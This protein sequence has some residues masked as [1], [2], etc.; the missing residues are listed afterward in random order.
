MTPANPACVK[1]EN[2]AFHAGSMACAAIRCKTV[3]SVSR[4]AELVRRWIEMFNR[5]GNPVEKLPVWGGVW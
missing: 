5:G 2:R 1:S 4:L 3:V